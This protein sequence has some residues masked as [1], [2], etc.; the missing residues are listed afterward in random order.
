[1]LIYLN[2]IKSYQ[3]PLEYIQAC[4]CHDVDYEY[5]KQHFDQL[6]LSINPSINQSSFPLFENN[7]PYD[8]EAG[9]IYNK[10]EANI[11]LII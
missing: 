9:G 3:F 6:V 11:R 10:S 7:I 5:L 4:R 8:K 2:D 1:M